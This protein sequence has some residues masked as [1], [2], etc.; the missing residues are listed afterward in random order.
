MSLR[1]ALAPPT[2]PRIPL[3]NRNNKEVV[4]LEKADKL[5][6]LQTDSFQTLVGN[7]EFRK[8]GMFLYCDSAQFFPNSSFKAFGNV[9]MRQGDTL[10][11]YA[12]SLWYDN[13][14][15]LA[16]LYAF[17][18][19]KVRL[20]NRDVKLETDEFYY[21]LAIE[22][23]YY[24]NWGEL[25]D[26]RNR[27]TSMIGEY[28]PATKDANFFNSV[29]LTSRRS[30]DTLIITTDTL[31]YNT[32]TH[33]AV[34]NCRTQIVNKD[35]VIYTDDGTYNTN[36]DVGQLFS[37]SMVVTKRGNTL[38]GDTLFYDS[39]KGY[40]EAFGNMILTDSARQTTL[41]GNYGFYNEL[42]D[43]IFV[44]GEAL[45][46]E[47][48]RPDTLY[49][50]GDTIRGFK[51]YL[52]EEQWNDTIVLLPDSTH[53]LIVQPKVRFFRKDIQGIC[54]SMTFIQL[55][56][57]LYM[58]KHPVVWSDNRQIFGN[59][60]QV[61]LN[62]STVDLVT[63]PN[64]AFSAEM[65]EE[66]YFDQ[67]SGREMIV[68]LD[69]GE[70]RHIDVNGNV[71]AITFPMENDSTYNKVVSVESSYLAADFEN[72][73]LDRMKVWPEVKSVITPLYLAKKS[74]FYLP[75][76]RWLEPLRPTDPADVF[77]V[78]EMMI[79]YMNEPEDITFRSNSAKKPDKSELPRGRKFEIHPLPPQMRDSIAY[80]IDPL[81]GDTLSIDTIQVPVVRNIP[82]PAPVDSVPSDSLVLPADSLTLPSDTIAG[83][84]PTT[85]D[86]DTVSGTEPAPKTIDM[87]GYKRPPRPESNEPMPSETVGVEIIEVERVETPPEPEAQEAEPVQEE[88]APDDAPRPR[89]G[90][91]PG[92]DDEDA[93]TADGK[94]DNKKDKKKKSDKKK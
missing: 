54:D 27:L 31:N 29:E 41:L 35:G 75:K 7:V 65:I 74:I 12:D 87:S 2:K 56:S 38:T 64:N 60:I 45:A 89:L 77:N 51:V 11:I 4:F 71:L 70:V 15:E 90:Y 23:A 42:T 88:A 72:Q 5:F 39:K 26:K 20:I 22:L 80:N 85:V 57:M 34:F 10:F 82:K 59:E 8:Q 81:T 55:D 33:I 92:D 43:S 86:T 40:G 21:D 28:S 63:L 13:P 46:M 48:S 94:K 66:G 58:D 49:L 6:A 9:R 78:S 36:S 25:T 61:H 83:E 24:E 18:G 16:T 37:R 14:L 30:G 19:K 53:Y 93:E 1:A 47:Y 69:S 67:L 79:A 62:D 17:P 44:T 32:D 84:A 73:E 50:H 76:F 3:A 52:P 91:V 68:Y